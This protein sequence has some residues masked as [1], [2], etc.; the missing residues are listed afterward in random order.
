MVDELFKAR[1]N[2]KNKIQGKERWNLILQEPT[3]DDN[4]EPFDNATQILK[5]AAKNKILIEEK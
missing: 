2:K 1:K 3:G 5:D 4:V